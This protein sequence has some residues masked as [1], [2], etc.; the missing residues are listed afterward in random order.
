MS[1]S[2]VELELDER[3]VLVVGDEGLKSRRI[4]KGEIDSF[5]VWADVG[6]DDCRGCFEVCD[7]ALDIKS[8]TNG[9]ICFPSD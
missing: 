8:T 7:V 3:G 9:L 1:S 2:S 5:K 4:F 6:G